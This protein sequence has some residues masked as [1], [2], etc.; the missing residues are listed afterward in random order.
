MKQISIVFL[1]LLVSTF[2]YAQI[3]DFTDDALRVELIVQGY[4]L[5]GDD[6]IEVSEAELIKD[7]FLSTG[8]ITSLD[9]IE[10]FQNLESLDIYEMM[11][12]VELSGLNAL[13]RIFLNGPLMTDLILYDLP[14]LTQLDY[15]AANVVLTDLEKLSNIVHLG[16][17][18][19]LTIDN[20]PSLI[21][22][23]P[24]S[25]NDLKITNCN[26]LKTIEL[27]DVAGVELSDLDSLDIITLNG[28]LVSNEL[29]ISNLPMLSSLEI[30][31][32]DLDSLDLSAVPSLQHLRL[33]FLHNITELRLDNLFNL[34][35]LNVEFMDLLEVLDVSDCIQLQ[36]LHCA[37]SQI[38]T[39]N[40][41]GL[42]NLD[43]IMVEEPLRF[44]F[45][46]DVPFTYEDFSNTL[47][48]NMDI[49]YI[50]VSE[51]KIS[52]V[53][54]LL[55]DNAVMN[56]IVDNECYDYSYNGYAYVRGESKIDGGMDGC[57]VNDVAKPHLSFDLDN[58]TKEVRIFSNKEGAFNYPLVE[59]QYVLT[60]VQIESPYYQISPSTVSFEIDSFGQEF[61]QDF[62][63]VPTGDFNDLRI[64]LIPLEEASPGFDVS[65]KLEYANVGT[66][67]QSGV[68]KCFYLQ[69]VMEIVDLSE[70][71]EDITASTLDWVFL[72]LEPFESRTID[73]HFNLN[74]PMETPP[75]NGGDFLVFSGSIIMLAE[76]DN[77]LDNDFRLYHEVVNSFDP[78]DKTCLEGDFMTPDKVGNYLTYK[79]RFEN[80]GTAPARN[81]AIVDTID[82]EVFDMMTLR[83]LD[84]SHPFE[85]EIDGNVVS[86]I[87]DGI[88]LP[89]DDENNDGYVVFEIKT[90]ETL[91]LDDSIE[92]TAEIFFDFN[93]PIV[94]NTSKVLVQ[95]PPP[96]DFD[97]DGF[98]S[99]VDCDDFNAAIYP[100]ATE[101][102]NNGIDEDCDGEDFTSSTS[103]IFAQSFDLYPNPTSSIL[104]IT[105]R[106]KGEFN[107]R[108]FDLNGQQ[109][110]SGVLETQINL[111]SLIEGCYILEIE[112]QES[113]DRCFKKLIVQ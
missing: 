34:K 61:V 83:P 58:G 51:D 37:F 46:R 76:D 108:L 16:L 40:I 75:L 89:F 36:Q 105:T 98:P 107:Y 11:E 111:S 49:E 47:L 65:Y 59:G 5:N 90:L 104:N 2:A 96:A 69:D 18:G 9:G 25:L 26:R 74:S 94:T 22:I 27:F 41:S 4:D 91:E 106:S 100:D 54:Q 24:G 12:T 44:L 86:F 92:N 63:L 20:L 67:T 93:W 73:M 62:C 66:T 88:Y 32:A 99:D 14:A 38:S 28:P 23:D 95:Y 7:L 56:A 55:E 87:F 72:D 50:C 57:D 6:E 39:L 64:S 103:D 81:I 53:E 77:P 35:T 52:I 85:T 109:V 113:G 70:A 8:M 110:K 21:S 10:H 97:N 84:G 71:P 13:Q 33:S 19:N 15:E 68:V 102:A 1:F 43:E 48:Y 29:K 30:E 42:T 78:N 112:E 79:I 101:I 3:I 45:A 80:T 31:H 82:T 17:Q 60:P